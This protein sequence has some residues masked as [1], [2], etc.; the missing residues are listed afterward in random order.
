MADNTVAPDLDLNNLSAEDFVEEIGTTSDFVRKEEK[1]VEPAQEEKIEAKEEDE[2]KSE[3]EPKET[4][5]DDDEKIPTIEDLEKAVKNLDAR[6]ES[7]SKE[8]KRLYQE[9]QDLKEQLSNFE[10]VKPVLDILAKNPEL[11]NIAKQMING[12]YQDA[13]PDETLDLDD[14]IRNPES[15]SAK[16]LD[17]LVERKAQAIL[18]A[19]TSRTK[20]TDDKKSRETALN[21]EIDSV[22]KDMKLSE[23]QITEIVDFARSKKNISFKDMVNLYNFEKNG[24]SKTDATT[25]ADMLKLIDQIKQLNKT[26]KKEAN[27]KGG[28][29]VEMSVEDKVAKMIREAGGHDLNDLI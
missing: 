18:N 16:I 23:D 17:K 10:E 7:S 28:N 6:Y 9:N 25:P 29:A 15:A 13:L 21:N 8:G 22:A 20:E 19:Q 12:T 27:V 11:Q 5:A 4:P 24:G 2:N 26:S 1:K 3:E 14:A